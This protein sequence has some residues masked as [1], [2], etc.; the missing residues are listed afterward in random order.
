MPVITRKATVFDRDPALA[1]RSTISASLSAIATTGLA[2]RIFTAA[3]AGGSYI[4]NSS[5]R[6]GPVILRAAGAA[7]AA[8][9]AATAGTDGESSTTEAAAA[10]ATAA[11]HSNVITISVVCIATATLTATTTG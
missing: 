11:G 9:A 6:V 3:A 1:V 2:I 7:T 5:F 10:A 8:T 4:I